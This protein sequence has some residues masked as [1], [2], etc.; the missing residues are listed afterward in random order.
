[1]TRIIPNMNQSVPSADSADNLLVKHVV[2]NKTDT[3]AG[4][5]LIALIKQVLVAVSEAMQL[6]VE[7]SVTGTIEEDGMVSFG[8]GLMD[9][10]TGAIASGSID[11]TG[12]SAVLDISTGGAAFAPV[13]TQPTFAKANGLVSVD[14]RFLAAEWANG[15]MYKLVVSGIECT[16]GADTAYVPALTWSGTLQE[17]LN[18]EGK[19]DT[20]DTV[21]DAIQVD[22]GDP[23]ARTN[24]Q[25]L[26]AL[27]GNPDTAG[28]TIYEA[29]KNIRET[30]IDGSST[31]TANTLS[32]TLH[33]DGSYTFDNTTDS[34]EALRD[35]MDAYDVTTQTDLDAII[36]AVI[37]NAAGAD[38]AADIIAMKAVVDAIDG[39]LDTEIA[40]IT[41]AVITNA[42]GADVA[43]DVVALKAVADAIQV[44]L[45]DYSAQTN[46][47][48][49]LAAL[50]IPDVA[51]KPLYTCLVTD[52]LDHATFGLSAIQVQVDDIQ[53]KIDGTDATATAYR[54]EK[55]VLQCEEFSVTSAANAGVTTF[56][57]VTTQ[58]CLIKSIVLH[59]D[60][61]T[62]ADL[63]SAAIKGGAGQVV[64]F[65]SAASAAK[66]NIDAADEQVNYTGAVWLPATQT[67]A[68]DLQ[69]TGA[70]AVD[71]TIV[72]EYCSSVDGGYLT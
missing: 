71:F 41:T 42:A 57:T 34:L 14:Y 65:I 25:S 8:I 26:L 50:G 46:L 20:I 66:A 15:D 67:L 11:I 49:L 4:D 61:A 24:L 22:I 32:D 47:Q 72:V 5:S 69:G 48:S 43:T 23:S 3:I 56:A 29:I 37:T 55:G 7:Q 9:I 33:K 36:A 19:I 1:M 12:I 70:T 52:R 13:G 35:A 21:V 30:A 54:R 27:L 6:R 10:D 31:P 40:A 17:G 64:E 45:G 58:G 68:I 28:K 38:V 16:V 59:S 62:T 63:T 60:G 39:Y 53:D 51:A 2:G 44:D 18:V